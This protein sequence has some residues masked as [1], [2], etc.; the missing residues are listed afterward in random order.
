M[1]VSRC[2]SLS[3][4]TREVAII[5]S[6]CPNASPYPVWSLERQDASSRGLVLSDKIYDFVQ[7]ILLNGSVDWMAIESAPKDG[8]ISGWKLTSFNVVLVDWLAVKS[9][10]KRSRRMCNRGTCTARCSLQY[11]R[12]ISLQVR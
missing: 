1:R 12:A 3:S 11:R 2:L 7:T 9:A 4:D 10:P 5:Y 8:G 6:L